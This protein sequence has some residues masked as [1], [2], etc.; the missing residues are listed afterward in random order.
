MNSLKQLVQAF[1]QCK[2][3]AD[4][5]NLLQGLLTSSEVEE[6]ARRLQIV[7]MVKKGIPHHD[8]AQTLGVGVATVS[9]GSKEVQLGRFKKVT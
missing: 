1:E 5:E 6:F 4:I 8:I 7:Q 3:A 2:T 9:R